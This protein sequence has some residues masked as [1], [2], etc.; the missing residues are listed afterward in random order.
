MGAPRSSFA[1]SE[2]HAVQ[3]ML[4]ETTEVL[5]RELVHPGARAPD[6]S[7]TEWA[8][9]RA[10]TVMHG[11]PGL[12]G[13]RLRWQ[14]PGDWGDFL[15]A[16]R[17]QIEQRLARIEPLLVAIDAAARA[18][19][20]ALIALKGAALHARGIYRVGERPMADVD[21][22]VAPAQEAR[23]G[24]L[25]EQ[26]GYREACATWKHR[27]F[28]PLHGQRHAASFG[29]DA[30]NPLRIELHAGIRELLPL[31]PVDISPLVLPPR[32]PPGLNDYA[33]TGTLLLHLVLHAAGAMLNRTLRFLHLHDIA[34]VAARMTPADWSDTLAAVRDTPDPS[35]WWAFPP[36]MLA[37]RYHGGVPEEVL[38]R[39][40]AGCSPLLRRLARRRLVSDVSLS[41]LWISAFPGIEWARSL[42]EA[43]SYAR[44]R[45]LPS[46][47]TRALRR[48]YADA[49]PLV[50]GGEWA[51][52]SQARRIVRYLTS[53]PARQETVQPVL[54]ALE[55]WG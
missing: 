31:R 9:A 55:R 5:A 49:Q 32:P 26:L 40:A 25:I 20:I 23:A 10:A 17:A 35:L 4:R 13:E 52:A 29:E 24:R 48:S 7:A 30:G 1:G 2:L 8:V 12:L 37:H 47:E 3:R 6:W 19:G 54:R 38:A 50:S 45:L 11:L 33:S 53:R 34:R 44:T 42:R 14:G 21:L 28:H 36:L 22:L 15:G 43:A 51:Q 41:Y 39:T 16:Q 27:E 18:E 46:A